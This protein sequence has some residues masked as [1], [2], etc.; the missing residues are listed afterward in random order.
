MPSL[1]DC[2]N[3]KLKCVSA[4]TGDT[5]SGWGTVNKLKE[6]ERFLEFTT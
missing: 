5:Q 2:L 6:T 4:V 3:S 1:K